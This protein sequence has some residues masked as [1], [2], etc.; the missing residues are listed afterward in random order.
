MSEPVANPK[1]KRVIPHSA[2]FRIVGDID[3]C[4][5]QDLLL[6]GNRMTQWLDWRAGLR[7]EPS[8]SKAAGGA[9]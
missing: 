1:P 8:W 6:L 5:Y 4:T 3:G 2:G 9:K 7:P